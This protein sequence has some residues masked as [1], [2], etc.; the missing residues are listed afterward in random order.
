MSVSHKRLAAS[1]LYQARCLS[2]ASLDLLLQ[3]IF[4]EDVG[5]KSAN[6]WG[7]APTQTHFRLQRIFL[8][9]RKTTKNKD[10]DTLT[11]LVDT[12]IRFLISRVFIPN[13]FVFHLNK[14]FAYVVKFITQYAYS[15]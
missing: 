10:F 4:V 6:K 14:G 13:F 15:G 1:S 12:P 9:M 2:L 8:S 5:H 11:F 3:K 7:T